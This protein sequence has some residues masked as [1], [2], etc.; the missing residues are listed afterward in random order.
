MRIVAAVLALSV[1]AGCGAPAVEPGSAGAGGAFPVTVVHGQGQAVVAAAPQR[2]VVLGAGDEQI[3]AALGAP[4]VGAVRNPVSADGA[5]L[6]VDPPVPAAVRTLDSLTPDLEA[7]AALRP[8]LIL[9]TT[10]QP[11]FAAAYDRIAAIAPTVSYRTALLQDPGEDLTR[12]IGTAL[13]RSAEAEALIARADEQIARFAAGRHTTGGYVYGQFAAGTLYLVTA[14]DSPSVRFL[15]RLGLTVPEPVARLPLW[16]AGMAQLAGEQLAL[17]DRARVAVI[18]VPTDADRAA[19]TTHP[20]VARTALAR[21]GRLHVVSS[22]VAALLLT[23][24]PA[25]TPALLEIL[26]P[27][28]EAS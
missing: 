28:L 11:T 16:Q 17:L 12:M 8:D 5:W 19:L 2:V 3:A 9:M 18:G 6:G 27:V 25:S 4:I 26:R 13:G 15:G 14:P 24:N 22:D 10:A 1:I 21:E 7:I 20:L 23:P